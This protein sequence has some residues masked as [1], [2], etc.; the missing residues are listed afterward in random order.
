MTFEIQNKTAIHVFELNTINQVPTIAPNLL[1]ECS[2]PLEQKVSMYQK[3]SNSSLP[4]YFHF[5]L[6]SYA[7]TLYD[8]V[9]QSLGS[10][11]AL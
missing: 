7:W 3:Y 4:I 8:I 9:V 10:R 6:F 5:Y 2:N 11:S 1:I